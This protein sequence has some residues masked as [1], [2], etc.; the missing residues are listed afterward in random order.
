[1]PTLIYVPRDAAALA[2]DA[3]AVAAAIELAA[4]ERGLAVQV[5]RNGSRGLLWLEPLVEISTP[6]GRLAYGP[7]QP[8]DVP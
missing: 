7:V 6:E 3:D 5:V 4:D 2:M 1:T 8:E